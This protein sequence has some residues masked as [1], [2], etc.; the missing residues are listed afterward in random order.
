M[1][2]C[3]QLTN[4]VSQSKEKN[5]KNT[6]SIL[7]FFSNYSG[8]K[9]FKRKEKKKFLLPQQNEINYNF[10]LHLIFIGIWSILSASVLNFFRKLVHG[11]ERWK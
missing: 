4:R 8:T 11:I 3:H 5:S 2:K 1:E 9:A 10:T 6:N 7:A